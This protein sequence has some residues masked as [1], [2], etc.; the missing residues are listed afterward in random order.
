MAD[1]FLFHDTVAY[2]STSVSQFNNS[3]LTACHIQDILYFFY[4]GIKLQQPNVKFTCNSAFNQDQVIQILDVSQRDDTE[5]HIF[6]IKVVHGAFR[7]LLPCNSK[8]LDL[9]K[10]VSSSSKL[11]THFIRLVLVDQLSTKQ[12]LFHL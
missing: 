10:L 3:S 4:V 1:F 7:I 2:F 6:S 11:S 9:W 5:L 8:F 12:V